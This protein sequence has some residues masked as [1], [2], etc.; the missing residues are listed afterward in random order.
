[1]RVTLGNMLKKMGHEV[2]EAV[3][4]EDAVIKYFELKP[5]LVTMDITMPK[6]DGAEAVKEIVKLDADAKIIMV[7]AMGQ[8]E[9]VAGAI[10]SGAKDFIVKP[11]NEDRV[12]MA[13]KRADITAS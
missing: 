5:D 4:G 3:D 1:M 2:F 9:F 11:F 12:L 8:K 6:K 7:S 10:R 13:L